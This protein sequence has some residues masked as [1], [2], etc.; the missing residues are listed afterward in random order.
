MQSSQRDGMESSYR[1]KK[2]HGCQTRT[3]QPIRLLTKDTSR[4]ENIISGVMAIS[5][6]LESGPWLPSKL[7]KLLSLVHIGQILAKHTQRVAPLPVQSSLR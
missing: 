3:L 1:R 5:N 2:Q 7:T 6:M 4:N